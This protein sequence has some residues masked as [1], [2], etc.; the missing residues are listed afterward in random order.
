[1]PILLNI[2][3]RCYEFSKINVLMANKVKTKIRKDL[4]ENKWIQILIGGIYSNRRPL[5]QNSRTAG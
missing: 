5:S 3:T 2:G 4:K 1:M